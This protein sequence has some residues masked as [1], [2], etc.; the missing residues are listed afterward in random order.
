MKMRRGAFAKLAGTTTGGVTN[1]IRTGLLPDRPD[2]MIDTEDPQAK[3]WLEKM[4]VVNGRIP[5]IDLPDPDTV[6]PAELESIDFDNPSAY[7]NRY[8]DLA[9]RDK[10]ATTLKRLIDIR[11]HEQA[12]RKEAGLLIEREYVAQRFAE[13]GEALRQQ[14]LTLPKRGA[15]QLTARARAEG[16]RA[17]EEYLAQEITAAIDKAL[18]ELS[19]A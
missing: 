13:F 16:E 3:A 10:A 19:I 9:S 5:A 12:R 15:P 8:K 18:E 6:T 7:L 14:L 17:V 11:R 2:K 1:A 4:A